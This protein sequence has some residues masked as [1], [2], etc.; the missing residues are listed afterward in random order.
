MGEWVSQVVEYSLVLAGGMLTGVFYFG[1]LW[2]T[3]RR[4]IPARRPAL[5]MLA[6][7]TV[8]TA[9]ALALFYVIMNGSRLRLV[10]ALAGFLVIRQALTWF[11]GPGSKTLRPELKGASHHEHHA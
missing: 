10:V 11:L 3:V 7:F 6:S 5:L 9:I 4:L 8:R 1:G 2:L